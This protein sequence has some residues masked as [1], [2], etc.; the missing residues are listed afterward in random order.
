MSVVDSRVVKLMFD[1]SNF[2]SNVGTSLSTIDKLKNALKFDKATDGLQTIGNTAKGIT[3]SAM[4]D[5]IFTVKNEFDALGIIAKRVLEDITDGVIK[6]GKSLIENVTIA[7]IKSGLEEYETQINSVQTILANTGDALK[8]QGLTSEHDRIEKINTVLDELNH[9]ADMTIYNFTEM[10]RNIGTFTAAGVDLDTAATAIQGIANLAAMSGSNSQQASTAMYQLSQAIASGSVKLQDWNSVV[11]AGMGGKLFQNELIDTAK[12]M[13]VM[14]EDFQ[15]L[16]N[17]ETTFR[18][19]LSSGWLSADVLTNTLE[20]FTAGTEGYTQAQLESMQQMWRARGYS[21][22]QIQELTS[23]VH[24]LT[25]E[26]E[27]NVRQKWYDKGFTEEQVN[28]IM[29]MGTAATNAATK[30]KTFTQL[31]DTVKEAMQSG[32]TQSWEYIF[33]DF[34][35]AKAFW[36]EISDIMNLYIGRS[37]DAR[38]GVLEA[39]SKATYSYDEQGRLIIAETGELVEGQKM[40]A[41][42][43]GGRELVI[44]GMRNTFQGMFEIVRQL[45]QAWDESFLGKGTDNDISITGDQLIALSRKFEEFT[46]NFKDSLTDADGN[47]TPRLTAIRNAFNDFATNMRT[48]YDGIRDVFSGIITIADSFFHSSFFNISTL[49]TAIDMLGKFTDLIK[50]FGTAFKENFASSGEDTKNREGLMKFFG[51]L[52]GLLEENIW[53][54]IELITSGLRALGDVIN[55]VIPDGETIATM[56]GKLGDKMST[57]AQAWN[58]FTHSEDVNRIDQMFQTLANGLTQFFDTIDQYVDFSGISAIFDAIVD[59]LSNDDGTRFEALTNVL[60]TIVNLFEAL[61]A[62]IAPVAAA[63]ASVLAPAIGECVDFIVQVIDRIHDFTEKLIISGPVMEGI[64]R[65]FEGIFTVIKTLAE[66]LGSAFVTAWDTLADKLSGILPPS[67]K[68]GDALKLAGDKLIEFSDKLKGFVSGNDTEETGNKV[69]T[70]GGKIKDFVANIKDLAIVDRLK[71]SIT[72][73]L[74]GLKHAMVGDEDISFLDALGKKLKGLIDNIKQLFSDDNGNLDAGKILTSG[75]I[76]FAVKKLIEFLKNLFNMASGG[77]QIIDTITSIGEAIADTFSNLAERIK[78]DSIK[79]IATA[80]LE[81]AGAVFVLAMI[82]GTSLAS[83]LGAIAALFELIK[84][85]LAEISNFST[86][87]TATLLGAAAAMQ[88]LGNA[89]LELAGAIFIIGSMDAED[90]VRGLIGVLVLM[91][92][93]VQVAEQFSNFDKDLAKGA[94]ALIAFSIA[95]D[96]LV[97]PVK[98]LGDME[99]NSF[100]QGLMGTIALMAALTG[101]AYELSQ[102]PIKFETGAAII[103][104]AAGVKMLAEAVEKL[105]SIPFENMIQGLIGVAGG[106]GAMVAAV[107]ILDEN[108]GNDA[109]VAAGESMLMMSIGL[110]A[111]AQAI[112]MVADLSLPQI[113]TALLGLCAPLAAFVA[114]CKLTSGVDM[115]ATGVGILAMSSAMVPLA[116]ALLMLSGLSLPEIGT[117]LVAIAGALTVMG[118]AA[119]VFTPEMAGTMTLVGAAVALVGVGMLAFGSGLAVLGA[120]ISADGVLLLWFLEQLI[121]FIPRV[122]TELADGLAN[123]ITTLADRL[124][125]IASSLVNLASTLLDLVTVDLLPKLFDFVE[126]LLSNLFETIGNLAPQFFDTLGTVFSSLWEFIREQIPEIFS[127]LSTLLQEICSF[128]SDNF[129]QIVQTISTCLQA[130]LEA[131]NTNAPLI[132]ETLITL[133]NTVLETINTAIPNIVTTLL[134][135][136][137]ECLKSLAEFIPQMADAALKIIQGFLQAVADNIGEITKSAINI[138]V[139]F[140]DGLAE[141]MPELVDSAFK[142]IISWI[143]GLAQAIEDNHDALFDAIGHLITAI[144]DAIIDGIGRVVEAGS[145]LLNDFIDNFSA[146][147]FI[148]GIF[149]AGANLVQGFINGVGSL[150][151]SLWEA[152]CG[153][154]QDAL[155]AITQTTDQHS[156]SKKTFEQGLN[157]AQG[158]IDGIDSLKSDVAESAGG[159]A[160]AALDAMSGVDE[161]EFA[162]TVTPVLDLSEVQNGM[163]TEE[164]DAVITRSINVNFE[165]FNNQQH[166]AIQSLTETVR[167]GYEEIIEQNQHANASIQELINQGINVISQLQLVLDTGTLVGEITPQINQALGTEYAMAERGVR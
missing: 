94:T 46:R 113:G 68:V 118:V 102:H 53:T 56:L 10:T 128:V 147:E 24:V 136:I 87:D 5:G 93:L 83:A 134:S 52:K 157:T 2:E 70:L 149:D 127:I 166:M 90:M 154:A 65:L 148:D 15:D 59:V 159:V 72:G 40:L 79:Q 164:L 1:N 34:E 66:I 36:T 140:M 74:D 21:E 54:K 12:A 105:G 77:S 28:H 143:E 114:V 130:I 7:P 145:N 8:D 97:I 50:D 138:A 30:V 146:Q 120:A 14:D 55:H 4:Q 116:G 9:Y 64:Q 78:V 22:Q 62:V 45:S 41:D 29:E 106:L 125:D 86:S 139:A 89:V 122:A 73:F 111:I 161:A 23:A 167:A 91:E 25:Q 95:L 144:V 58:T 142:L 75:G 63:F 47:A 99:W 37:A 57:F 101:V 76:V 42:A 119:A 124:G 81:I 132:G 150:G 33:G 141:K 160:T 6:V 152:A 67:E 88:T 43:M 61:G 151:A 104:I 92:S 110:I 39:W 107:I 48:A 115:V 80:L 121:T 100:A 112:T 19:S 158:Y 117:G 135:L 27:A 20:K 129:P 3:F 126:S 26:E 11:N 35:Q 49:D 162:P 16:I 13:G 165:E 108:V 17:N 44:Q 38:N 153:I 60:D 51:G 69:E 133:L 85:L 137:T 123:F 131:I 156:P 163:H 18:E 71:E 96:L 84:R 82:D 98:T 155:D 32:W 31:L 109:M 103:Q